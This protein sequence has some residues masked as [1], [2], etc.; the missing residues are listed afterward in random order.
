MDVLKFG[1]QMIKIIEKF[2]MLGYVHR[3]IKPDNILIEPTKK[4]KIFDGQ[5]IGIESEKRENSQRRRLQLDSANFYHSKVWNT[6]ELFLIDF[7]TSHK[8]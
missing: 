8:Y 7:G 5:V 6:S 1:L 4:G 2:H 3:D